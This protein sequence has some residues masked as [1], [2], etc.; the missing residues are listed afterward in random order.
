M[1]WL[2]PNLILVAED[3]PGDAY[4]LREALSREI[5]QCEVRLLHDGDEA[6]K[7][8]SR[9]EPFAGVARPDL[10]VLDLNL[11]KRDGVELLRYIRDCDDLR[12]LPVAVLSSAPEDVA[13]RSLPH[14]DCYIKKPMRLTE[15]MAIGRVVLECYH[16][17]RSAAAQEAAEPVAR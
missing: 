8:L 1:N 2:E 12:H 9:S 17:V 15:F 7:F 5:P 4:L 11:P 14:A 13:L 3:N 6:Y 10:I 16:R